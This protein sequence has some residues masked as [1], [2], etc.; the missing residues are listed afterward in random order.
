M[1]GEADTP[2]QQF[3]PVLGD[4][5]CFALY[6]ASRAVT[7]RYRPLLEPL[8]LTYPQF[9]VL[10]ALWQQNA[11][12]IKE[13]G[14]V[15]QLD[16]GTLTPLIKRLETAGLLCRERRTDDERTVLVTLTPEGRALRAR[17]SHIPTAMGH[18]MALT[19]TQFDQARTLL[20][21]LT[22]NVSQ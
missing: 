12:P 19:P 15:L 16:Y 10:L 21:L 9:L 7:T 8:G 18:A 14:A 2:E 20:H 22:A 1:D 5:L 17:A 4:Q 3:S 11:V 6:A 13:I